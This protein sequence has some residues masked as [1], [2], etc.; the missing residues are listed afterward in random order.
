MPAIPVRKG[1]CAVMTS[2]WRW[3]KIL[4]PTRIVLSRADNLPL[5]R[6]GTTLTVLLKRRSRYTSGRFGAHTMTTYS[7]KCDPYSTWRL[8]VSVVLALLV[9]NSFARLSERTLNCSGPNAQKSSFLSDANV[10][11]A[12]HR[13]PGTNPSAL[14]HLLPGPAHTQ[15]QTLGERHHAARR[16]VI[17]CGLASGFSQP[18]SFFRIS[19]HPLK[20]HS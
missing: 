11:L 5:P 7:A 17:R 1:S 13:N 18:S 4:A 3:R 9:A 10:I 6:A 8:P 14:P 12:T 15:Q 2:N 19:Q 20:R 16:E